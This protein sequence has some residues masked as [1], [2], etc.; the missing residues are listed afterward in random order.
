MGLG[1]NAVLC[2]VN[3]EVLNEKVAEINQKAQGK[4]LGYVCGF[5][6]V[7]QPTYEGSPLL[8]N[9]LKIKQGL[10]L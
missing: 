9:V 4:A 7:I 10:K 3:E 1:G 8:F 6:S 2:D 5:A